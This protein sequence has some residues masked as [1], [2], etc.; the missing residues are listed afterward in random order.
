M[1][2]QSDRCEP[3]R[4][5]LRRVELEIQECLEVIG[6]PDILA[7]I[8]ARCKRILPSLR[9]LRTRLIAALKACEALPA[10]PAHR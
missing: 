10:H 7:S 4:E 3:L 5:Q 2:R 9:A 8:K 6:D 1:A